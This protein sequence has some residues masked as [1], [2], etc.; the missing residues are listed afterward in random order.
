MQRLF[1]YI[2]ASHPLTIVYLSVA[3]ILEYRGE[4]EENVDEF[5]S[6]VCF[7]VFKSP[8]DR[9]SSLETTERVICRARQ[10]QEDYPVQ[11]LLQWAEDDK[12]I[13]VNSHPKSPFRQQHTGSLV[14]FEQTL[15]E[16]KQNT[17]AQQDYKK[18]L[19]IKEDI[20]QRN[21]E[22]AV[23]RIIQELDKGIDGDKLPSCGEER[24]LRAS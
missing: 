6:S 15:E 17:K 14:G 13:R 1:D 11:T 19:K 8:L 7:F 20:E 5:Q 16:A 2:L 10:L 21:K 18:K 22:E 24:N 12:Q 4:L 9:L 3:V 23:R